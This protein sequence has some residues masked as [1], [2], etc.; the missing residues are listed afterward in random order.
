M[1]IGL[2]GH[3]QILLRAIVASTV[4]KSRQNETFAKMGASAGLSFIIGPI[5]GG[6]LNSTENGF[7][8]I[9]VILNIFTAINLG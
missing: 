5:L 3:V 8:K 4:P 7:F 2:T 9:A 1:L 6:I